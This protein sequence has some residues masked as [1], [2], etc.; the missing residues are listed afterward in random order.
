[1]CDVAE[2]CAG[3]SASCPPD[4]KSTALC[5]AAVDVCDTAE[6]CSGASNDCPPDAVQPASTEC[7]AAGGQC[8]VAERCTGAT[9]SCPADASAPNGTTCN[10]GNVCTTDDQCVFGICG[11]ALE[12]CGDRIV[13]ASC[14]E[15]CDDGNTIPGDGCSEICTLEPCGPAP[16]IGCRGPVVTG[17]GGLQLSNRTP[18]DKDRLQWK[19]LRGALTAK[20]DFGSP[21]TTTDYRLCIYDETGGSPH[22][23][24]SL[25]A[26]AGGD[27]SGRVCWRETSTG[28]KYLD[29]ALTPDGIASI[30][31]K[32][33]RVAG[34]TR[35]LVKGRGSALPM[36]ALPLDQDEDVLVQLKSSAGPCWEARYSAPAQKNRS[37]QFKDR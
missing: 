9:A 29:K 37:D 14:V 35:I 6:S 11:G 2:V 5:R 22:L 18:D 4:G 13:D 3:D 25:A 16:V 17:K 31:L 26:P 33:G 1:V 21:T 23:V 28:F 15:E 32:E 36:P 12:S 34:S 10:D 8:D 30:L 24:A 27:C 19:Y 20:A 7:R